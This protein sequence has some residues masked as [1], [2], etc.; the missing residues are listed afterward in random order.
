MPEPV[1]PA[2]LRPAVFKI[3]KANHSASATERINAQ[4]RVG[5]NVFELCIR[6]KGERRVV[7]H[8][9]HVRFFVHVRHHNDELRFKSAVQPIYS[10][11]LNA[12]VRNRA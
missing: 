10:A 12:S 11:A 2:P 8:F 4:G 5:I 6:Q 9:L 7:G 3:N 1:L